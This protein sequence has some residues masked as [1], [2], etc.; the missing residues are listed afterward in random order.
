MCNGKLLTWFEPERRILFARHTCVGN[1]LVYLEKMLPIRSVMITIPKE[2]SI[3][4]NFIF[5]SFILGKD[6]GKKYSLFNRRHF[7]IVT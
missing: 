7:L 6:S 1:F 5:E 4:G 3:I 2:E